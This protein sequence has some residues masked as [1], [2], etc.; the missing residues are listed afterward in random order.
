MLAEG[1]CF[2]SS[3][4]NWIPIGLVTNWLSGEFNPIL[5]YMPFFTEMRRVEIGGRLCHNS[6]LG[7]VFT[8]S[9]GINYRLVLGFTRSSNENFP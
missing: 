6:T 9:L 1:V 3:V 4:K 2:N 8:L 7:M 5:S